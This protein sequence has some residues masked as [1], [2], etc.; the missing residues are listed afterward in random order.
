MALWKKLNADVIPCVWGSPQSLTRAYKYINN[1]YE[2]SLAILGEGLN[3]AQGV[4]YGKRYWRI[5]IGPWLYYYISTAYEKYAS[6]Q[7]AFEKYR[8]V[9]IAT[10][11]ASEESFVIPRDTLDFVQ[12]LKEDPYNLQMYT[13]IIHHM[14]IGF[15]RK[16]IKISRRIFGPPRKIGFFESAVKN[17]LKKILKPIEHLCQ[18]NR[19]VVFKNTYSTRWA[20]LRLILYTAGKFWPNNAELLDL[21]LLSVDFALRSRLEGL[22]QSGDEFE[23]I[24]RKMLP[25]DIPQ[26]F[27]EGFS[28][29]K[30][31]VNKGYPKNNRAIFTS[32]SWYF[33]EAFKHWAGV[34]SQERGVLLLGG[35]HGGNYGSIALFPTE[36]HEIAITD[37]F[38]SWGWSDELYKS[39]VR[40]MP[41]AKYILK[42]KFTADNKKQGIL[43]AT[44]I[45][46]RYFCFFPFLSRNFSC[47]LDWQVRFLEHLPPGL[48]EVLRVRL[49]REDLGWD[50]QE[51]LKDLYPQITLENWDTPFL[52]SLKPCRLLIS[53][54]LASTFIDALA[55]NKPVVLFWN[56]ESNMLRPDARSY[57][58]ELRQAG[59]L[60]HNPEEAATAV[61]QIYND[62]ESWWN[63]PRRKIIRREFCNRFALT[64]QNPVKE[65]AQE[66]S[67]VTGLN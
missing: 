40:P 51:R 64:S 30:D 1:V 63:D 53:D 5:M 44:G 29:M 49:H 47:Y 4:S 50:I 20:E 57:Y 58:E 67:R 7:A 14:G 38:Y 8:P 17:S 52:K 55:L 59:I 19:P 9:D 39:K 16:K 13:K 61:C 43:F 33:D 6:L 28:I 41:A 35:Q 60:Y 25:F 3:R 10:I 54:N 37:C 32:N 15:P 18:D 65:W 48:R 11:G 21:P 24:L 56:P 66:L 36:A 22:F 62:V 46:F 34:S 26:C 27:L 45:L 42:K 31:Y 23:G 12:Y 2:N